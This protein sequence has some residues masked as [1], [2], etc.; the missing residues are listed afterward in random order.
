MFG[1]HRHTGPAAGA[2]PPEAAVEVHLEW[3]IEAVQQAVVA[4][5]QNPGESARQ[6]LLAGLEK[7]DNQIDLGDAYA[8]SVVNSPIFG[9]APKG[10]VLGETSSHSMAEDVPSPVVRAQISLVRAA[11]AAV[12]EPTSGAV[13][14]LRAAND[15]LAALDSQSGPTTT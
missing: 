7:L 14:E 6:S 3:D 10:G 2:A 5:L 9:Q 15:A 1:R 4:F 13:E 8:A 12:R 11:K